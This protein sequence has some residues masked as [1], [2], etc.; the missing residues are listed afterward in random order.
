MKKKLLHLTVNGRPAEVAV[1]PGRTLV[2]VLREDLGL[3]GTKRA[4]NSGACSSCTVVL[5]GKI[6]NACSVL[7]LQAEGKEVTTIEGV[8]EGPK[9]HPLQ[10]AFLDKGGFQCGFCTPGMILTARA[11][12][13]ENADPSAEEVREGIA[14]NLCRCTGYVKIVDAVLTAAER[15]REARS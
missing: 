12:L 5:D 14:G 9:L 11:L 7:A 10:E 8:A 4:C 3:T 2:Q 6:V 1:K 13:E 15:M